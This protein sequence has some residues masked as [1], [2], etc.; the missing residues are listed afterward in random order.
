MRTARRRANWI[1]TLVREYETHADVVAVG[2]E[3]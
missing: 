3:V 2:G 1:S